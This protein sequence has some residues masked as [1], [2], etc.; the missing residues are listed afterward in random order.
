MRTKPGVGWVA[1]ARNV[2]IAGQA[3]VACNVQIFVHEIV[4]ENRDLVF[5]YLKKI[6]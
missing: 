3:A 2:Q 5:F 1:A 4:F 6:S